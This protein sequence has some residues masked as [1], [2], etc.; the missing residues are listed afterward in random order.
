[1]NSHLKTRTGLMASDLEDWAGSTYRLS[2]NIHLTDAEREM[3]CAAGDVLKRVANMVR[4]RALDEINRA[5]PVL[6]E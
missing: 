3:V 5:V 2:S 1:M 6:P 4:D